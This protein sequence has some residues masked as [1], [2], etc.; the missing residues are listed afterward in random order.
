[1]IDY[2]AARL[3]MVDAQLRTNRI[4]DPALIEAFLTVPRERFVPEPLKGTAYVDEDIPVGAGRYLIEPLVLARLLQLAQ[5]Q[6][7][8]RA[9]YL[10]AGTGYGAAILGR[11]A[12]SVI[13]LEP[14]PLLAVEARR[15]LSGLGC[16]NVA[17]VEGPLD[18]GHAPGA[19]YD[20]I[21]VGGAITRLSDI[22]ADQLGEGR[23]LVAVMKP[24]SRVGQATVM[25]RAG[26]V[27]SRRPSF[28]AATGLLPGFEPQLGFVF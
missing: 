7:T 13:A 4:T 16:T 20:V 26:R 8:D 12:R 6:P 10:G 21:V 14:D 22:V 23:R 5:V 17:L 11:L 24:D 3:N 28:D 15:Q 18:R 2:A 1:M 25:T 9:L 19:P 27:L